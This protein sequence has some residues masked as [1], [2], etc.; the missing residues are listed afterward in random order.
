MYFSRMNSAFTTLLAASSRSV[1]G[2]WR[3]E[4]GGFQSQLATEETGRQ[5]QQDPEIGLG[6]SI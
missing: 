1:K 5:G 2:T 4:S 3:K 6:G